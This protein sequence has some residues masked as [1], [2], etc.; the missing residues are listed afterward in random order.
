MA[1]VIGI[2]A[3]RSRS[4]T[5]PKPRDPAVANLEA[6]PGTAGPRRKSNNFLI[7]PCCSAI[8]LR[9]LWLRS[10]I[11]S[12]LAVSRRNETRNGGRENATCPGS[13]DRRCVHPQAEAGDDRKADRN[14]GLDRRRKP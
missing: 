10:A 12:V 5:H 8:A 1:S 14:D 2:E 9:P 4:A 11:A 3:R 13:C 7:I 6:L